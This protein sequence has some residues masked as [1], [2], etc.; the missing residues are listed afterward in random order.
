M[1]IKFRSELG[2]LLDYYYNLPR[3]VCEAGCAEGLFS[4]QICEWGID[5][6]F[7]IDNWETIKGQSGDG[8]FDNSWHSKN[9]EEAV[10]RVKPWEE[11]VSIMKGMTKDMIPII[12]D[13]YLGM[14]YIDAAHDYDSVLN[15]LELSYP[16]VVMGGIISG[17]DY[18]GYP[19]VN[20]AVNE[21]CKKRGLEI[22]VVPDEEP[23]MAS[24]WCIKK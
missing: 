15:D 5:R 3:I 11:K 17:H 22:N 16:K 8:G 21:F 2:K 18:L 1:E 13:R 14:I 24:F 12:P 19:S 4:K 20:R 6:F 9:Y 7:M 10:A 23:A